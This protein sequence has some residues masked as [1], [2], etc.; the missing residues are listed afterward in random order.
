M[1]TWSRLLKVLCATVKEN[2]YLDFLKLIRTKMNIYYY[3]KFKK[4]TN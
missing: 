4:L 3:L 2:I 1:T